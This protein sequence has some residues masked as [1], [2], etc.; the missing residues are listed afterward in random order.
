MIRLLFHLFGA[1]QFCYGC[2]Y[3]QVHVTPPSTSTSVTPFGGKLKYLTHLDAII[4]TVYFTIALMNDL[5]GN[6][7][8]TPSEKPLI[9]RIK[10]IMFSALAFPVAMFVGI[11]FWGIYA[12]DRELILPRS[13][14]PYFPTWLNHVLHTNIMVFILI[15]L[16]T[17]FRMYP[18]KKIGFSILCTF[19]LSYMVWIHIIYFKTGSWV[20]P[21]LNVLNWPVRII[22]YVICLGLVCSLYNVGERLNRYVWYK[23][24][25]QT[26]KSGKKKAK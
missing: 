8:P 5:F 3:D 23:E 15:D 22:F 26:V 11:T 7:E 16:I 1:I 4:Q 18:R 14:D 25:E 21:I 9:R 24:V 17:S 2:Y 20:Y 19:M 13:L 6:N 12:I 10:D